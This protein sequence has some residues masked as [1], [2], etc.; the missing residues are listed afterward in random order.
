M[1]LGILY[2][3]QPCWPNQ[4]T[5]LSRFSYACPKSSSSFC[6][7]KGRIPAA[8]V[9]LYLLLSAQDSTHFQQP[10]QDLNSCLVCDGK[11]AKICSKNTA[12]HYIDSTP[13]L[14]SWFQTRCPT[15][16][17]QLFLPASPGS[18]CGSPVSLLIRL[19]MLHPLS[20]MNVWIRHG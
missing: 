20:V 9:F 13:L 6:Y 19:Q 15:P 8:C 3:D 1:E 4:H 5:L 18:D 14:G 7:L 16:P 12:L 2:W 10:H 17:S 11:K